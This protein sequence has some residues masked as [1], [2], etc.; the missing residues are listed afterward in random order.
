MQSGNTYQGSLVDTSVDVGGGAPRTQ[1]S[2]GAAESRVQEAPQAINST[3]M[4]PLEFGF[5]DED[6]IS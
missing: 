6:G 4:D 5:D 3:T 1:T 2:G